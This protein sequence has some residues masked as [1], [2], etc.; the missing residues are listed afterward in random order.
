[1]LFL[2]LKATWKILISSDYTKFR[3]KSDS[4]MI[5]YKKKEKIKYTNAILFNHDSKFRNTKF[6]FPRIINGLINKKNCF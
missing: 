2:L 5:K 3:I 4:T 6:L 1:M